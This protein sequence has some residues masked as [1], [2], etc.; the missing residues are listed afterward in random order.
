MCS[1][2]IVLNGNYGGFCLSEGVKRFFPDLGH[3]KQNSIKVRTDR[4][5]VEF[6]EGDDYQGDLYIEQIPKDIFDATMMFHTPSCPVWNTRFFRIKEYDGC[7]SL[8]VHTETFAYFKY[9]QDTEKKEGKVKGI[10]SS[11]ELTDGEKLNAI[12]EI[13][14]TDS[15]D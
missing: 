12:A 7:E 13:F 3:E 6:V 1:V 4:A 9:Q 11:K 5:L 8:E 14:F 15:E 2:P 10:L